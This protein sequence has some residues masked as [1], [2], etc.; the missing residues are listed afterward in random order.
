M[1]VEAGLAQRAAAVEE[2]AQA[3]SSVWRRRQQVAA[4]EVKVLSRGMA[5]QRLLCCIAMA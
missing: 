5:L 1:E 4:Q 2:L 3:A